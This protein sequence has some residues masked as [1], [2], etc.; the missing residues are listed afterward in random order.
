METTPTSSS[1]LLS[2]DDTHEED[3]EMT[4][5]TTFRG[6]EHLLHPMGAMRQKRGRQ[7]LIA[8]IVERQRTDASGKRVINADELAMISQLLSRDATDRA[9]AKGIEYERVEKKFNGGIR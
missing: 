6:L 3:I 5:Q 4:H 9:R 8:S 2:F 1:S 7:L